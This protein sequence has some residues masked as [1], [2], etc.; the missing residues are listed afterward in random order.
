MGRDLL[1]A[2]LASLPD[3]GIND[4][5]DESE[6]LD[7]YFESALS[8]RVGSQSTFRV[9]YT[10]PNVA[11]DSNGDDEDAEEQPVVFVCHHG[12]GYSGL[13]FA[14]LAK[15]VHRSSNGKA[16]VLSLDCRG[17]GKSEVFEESNMD[18]QVLTDDLTAVLKEIF[19]EKL[20]TPSLM[21]VGHSMGGSVVVR[22]CAAIQQ[23]VGNVIGLVNLDVVEGTAI[24]FLDRMKSIIQSIPTEFDS[25][26]DAIA[27]HLRSKTISNLNSARVSV[28]PLLRYKVPSPTLDRGKYKKQVDPSFVWRA[29]L[30]ATEPYWRG[31]FEGLS[32]AFLTQR[33]AKLLVL[34]GAESLDKDLM[35][36]QM[37][38]KY[39]L[40]VFGDVGHCLQE[41]APERLADLL[42]DFWRRNQV[43]D[44]LKKVKKRPPY[45]ED[46]GY[47][48]DPDGDGPGGPDGGPGGYGGGP[49]M[50]EMDQYGNSSRGGQ[51]GAPFASLMMARK[52]LSVLALLAV[53]ALEA[54]IAIQDAKLSPLASVLQTAGRARS[55]IFHLG[56][57]VAIAGLLFLELPGSPQAAEILMAN[58]MVL[59]RSA[60]IGTVNY[61]AAYV[62]VI[63]G[64]LG[65]TLSIVFLG[66]LKSASPTP[67]MSESPM[68][69]GM[70]PED[71][72]PI[73]Y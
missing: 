26:E 23:Q 7:N 9:Y 49:P 20:K 58:R 64:L 28:P 29:N 39:Q 4:N 32:S 16:G 41:D 27:W 3:I 71:E 52:G 67:S 12:A 14:L 24:E 25:A 5:D 70:G 19:P 45:P 34:A 73:P 66:K 42:L 47:D 60:I 40:S 56:N 6:E 1:R 57:C 48:M 50:D 61:I 72:P 53:F 43:V 18:I 33:C 62:L 38:G 36:G 46:D 37:Q 59:P 65:L 55:V 2:R 21:L 22:A 11:G 54:A 17:H 44:I 31:W 13:S 51:G 15:Q 8:I 10:P 30:A 68:E 69:Y 63:T 35:I